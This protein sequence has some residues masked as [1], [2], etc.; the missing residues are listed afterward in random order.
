[1]SLR[2]DL[3]ERAAEALLA[4]RP[5]DD[6]PELTEA[7]G[8][9]RSLADAPAPAP[10]ATLAAMLA[11]GL[12]PTE[13]AAAPPVAAPRAVS[14]RQRSWALP[15]QLSLAGAGC[16]ALVLGA[17]AANELPAPA[18]TAVADVVE[19]VTPL[20]VPRPPARRPAPAVS[21][22]PPAVPAVESTPAP[23]KSDDRDHPSSRSTTTPNA[24][25]HARGGRGEQQSGEGRHG[26]GDQD[27]NSHDGASG[28]SAPRP[29][30]SDDDV[31]NGGS[32]GGGRDDSSS[33]GGG[34]A[35]RDGGGQER[36]GGNQP[37]EH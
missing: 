3:D 35:G 4:G 13:T 12:T 32:S 34:H 20:H 26:R 36:S 24:D 8:L 2:R 6:E 23:R 30:R 37:D 17:A 22:T 21:P 1:M 28:S 33:D 31:H 25:D 11:G 16:L 15:L 5:V 9:V 29:S 7:I 14:W 10:S 18:Q 27:S 19:A